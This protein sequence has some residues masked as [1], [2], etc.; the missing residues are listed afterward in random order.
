M[1]RLKGVPIISKPPETGEIDIGGVVTDRKPWPDRGGKK[2]RGSA[3]TLEAGEFCR[4]GRKRGKDQK[5]P[6]PIKF[7]MK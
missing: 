5:N 3:K 2:V 4:E 1:S 7:G 6:A